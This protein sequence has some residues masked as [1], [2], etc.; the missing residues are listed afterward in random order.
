MKDDC[1]IDGHG[2]FQG[3]QRDGKEYPGIAVDE[4]RLRPLGRAL[5]WTH[6]GV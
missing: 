3:K 5:W 6:F 4:Q 2:M 1:E